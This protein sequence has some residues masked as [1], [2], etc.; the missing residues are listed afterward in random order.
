MTIDPE[1]RTLTDADIETVVRGSA[2]ATLETD[3]DTKDADDVDDT[4]AGDTDE[5]D[6][7]DDATDESGGDTDTTDS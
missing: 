1:E 3:P 4:D 7:D 5:S 2:S 6:A